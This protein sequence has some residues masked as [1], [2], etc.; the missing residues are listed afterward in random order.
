MDYSIQVIKVIADHL[1]SEISIFQLDVSMME[2]EEKPGYALVD[3][4]FFDIPEHLQNHIDHEA[5]GSDYSMNS[6][7]ESL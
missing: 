7:G 1:D 5:I 2:D 4:G 6:T 3:E